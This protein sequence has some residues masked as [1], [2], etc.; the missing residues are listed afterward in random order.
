MV[1]LIFKF[2]FEVY[3]LK[4]SPSFEIYIERRKEFCYFSLGEKN[5][6]KR[7]AFGYGPDSGKH[8]PTSFDFK[9]EFKYKFSWAP[10]TVLLAEVL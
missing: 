6:E 1:F 8:T 10:N 3:F 2:C 4:E 7:R 5:C 9:Q